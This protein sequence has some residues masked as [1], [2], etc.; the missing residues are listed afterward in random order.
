MF[1]SI[2]ELSDVSLAFMLFQP[3]YLDAVKSLPRP[4]PIPVRDIQSVKEDGDKEE[5]VSAFSCI[6]IVFLDSLSI[7]FVDIMVL[8]MKMWHHTYK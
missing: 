4:L 7:F 8:H 5:E 6:H 3:Q 1:L 2:L